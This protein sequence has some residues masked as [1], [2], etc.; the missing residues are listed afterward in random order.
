DSV[1]GQITVDFDDPPNM[2]APVAKPLLL[3]VL[4]RIGAAIEDLDDWETRVAGKAVILTGKLSERG[5]RQ[6]L[7]PFIRPAAMNIIESES[8]GT[9]S[10]NP[11][12]VA[13][14]RYFRSVQTLLNDL[15]VQKT[16]TFQQ[17]AY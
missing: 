4:E 13:S 15:K 6:V 3:G 1:N 9:L 5:L 17:L 11:K 2:L 10:Q 7:S 16:K 12:A 14:Q 8:P